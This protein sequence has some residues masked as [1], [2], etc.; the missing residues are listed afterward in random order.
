MTGDP[1]P[2]LGA[3]VK[4]S[5]PESIELL[6]IAGFDF[7]VIDAEHGAV[8]I[9]TTS[10]MI[11]ARR[12]AALGPGSVGAAGICGGGGQGAAVVLQAV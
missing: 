1:F 10:T 9:R 5:A 11:L 3:W 2:R 6:A 4:L 12:V 7:V 8:D